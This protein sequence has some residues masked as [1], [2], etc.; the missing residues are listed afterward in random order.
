MI[1]G[2]LFTVVAILIVATVLFAGGD[3]KALEEKMAISADGKIYQILRMKG[4]SA[5]EAKEVMELPRFPQV[6]Y[7]AKVIPP[8]RCLII[9]EDLSE[10][11]IMEFEE[12]CEPRII[13][14]GRR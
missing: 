13:E 14:L 1:K 12:I 4:L 6:D 5:D 2:I 11:F 9:K 3:Y 8:Q 7:E 10:I